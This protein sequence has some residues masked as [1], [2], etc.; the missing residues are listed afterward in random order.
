LPYYQILGTGSSRAYFNPDIDI[1][2]LGLIFR[3]NFENLVRYPTMVLGESVGKVKHVVVY[4]LPFYAGWF[5]KRM[6]GNFGALESFAV[7]D[8]KEWEVGTSRWGTRGGPSGAMD[9]EALREGLRPAVLRLE[10]LVEVTDEELLLPARGE[11]R[12]LVGQVR[13]VWKGF[14][15]KGLDVKVVRLPFPGVEEGE[16]FKGRVLSMSTRGLKEQNVTRGNVTGKRTGDGSLR[17]PWRYL[18][19]LLSKSAL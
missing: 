1:L 5:Q 9:Y 4:N 6:L 14:N 7:L 15:E 17:K 10:K 3:T 19:M 2:M 8:L 16:G 12:R 11:F 18:R 13:G